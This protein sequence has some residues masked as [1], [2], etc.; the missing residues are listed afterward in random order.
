MFEYSLLNIH[1]CV[2]VT[3]TNIMLNEYFVKERKVRMSESLLTFMCYYI[4]VCEKPKYQKSPVRLYAYVIGGA[5]G[6]MVIV[7]GNGDSDTSSTSGRD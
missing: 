3:K 6:V 4:G 2:C 7:E 5:S 1:V